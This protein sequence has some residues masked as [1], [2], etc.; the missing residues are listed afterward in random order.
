MSEMLAASATFVGEA[1]VEGKLYNIGSFPGLVTG[2]DGSRV[3]GEIY[4]IRTEDLLDYLDWYEAC[5]ERPLP[6]F[7]RRSVEAEMS[8]GTVVNAWAYFYARSVKGLE[9]IESG[10]YLAWH[11]YEYSTT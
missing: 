4:E 7:Q 10:D 2:E 9:P 1:T 3:L 5:G 6:L 8:D 11:R